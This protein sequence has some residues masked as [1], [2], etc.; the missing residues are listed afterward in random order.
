M[1]HIFSRLV[2]EGRLTIQGD[3]CLHGSA[4]P[5]REG[6][7]SFCRN[8]ERSIIRLTEAVL[9]T[10]ISSLNVPTCPVVCAF[11]LLDG[12]GAQS[13]ICSHVFG[14]VAESL[15]IEFFWWFTNSDCLDEVHTDLLYILKCFRITCFSKSSILRYC[16]CVES[17]KC[18]KPV[19]IA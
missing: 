12:A 6:H 16:S 10:G 8:P 4:I 13:A 9:R 7:K 1:A 5:R 2:L 15:I 19:A 11:R 18:N 17:K 3:N 14:I